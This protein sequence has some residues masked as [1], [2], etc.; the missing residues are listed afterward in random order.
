MTNLTALVGELEA[1]LAKATPVREGWNLRVK[2][3]G[4]ER[5]ELIGDPCGFPVATF[6]DHNDAALDLACRKHLPILLATLKA[7]REA[8][9]PF[10]ALADKFC[11]PMVEVCTPTPNN[12]SPIIQPIPLGY[13]RRARASIEG[14]P[15]A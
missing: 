4:E 15:T 13:F 10:A 3:D 9:E 8:L 6:G 1:M 11:G 14:N 12:P 2:D 5:Y 7:Q